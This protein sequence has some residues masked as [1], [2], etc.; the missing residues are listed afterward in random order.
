MTDMHGTH[1][2]NNISER[3]TL[4]PTS[5]QELS[6][7][8]FV[9]EPLDPEVVVKIKIVEE[10]FGSGA[11]QIENMQGQC[12]DKGY[13]EE[14]SLDGVQL[15]Q[16]K[17]EPS[18][19]EDTYYIYHKDLDVHNETVEMDN[20][21]VYE[22]MIASSETIS[23]KI[24]GKVNEQ[25]KVADGDTVTEP[26][27]VD[28]DTVTEPVKVVGGTVNE[29]VKVKKATMAVKYKNLKESLKNNWSFLYNCTLLWSNE[30]CI[31]YAKFYHGEATTIQLSVK[32]RSDFT[33]LIQVHGMN[34]SP[35][36]VFW[37]GLPEKYTTLGDIVKLLTKLHG[38]TVC[39]GN[40]DKEYQSLIK[41]HVESCQ[42]PQAYVEGDFGAVKDGVS[43]T[44]SIR[45]TAC[46]LLTKS[47][48]CRKCFLYRNMLTKAKT[49]EMKDKENT[50]SGE[51]NLEA[52]LMV[53]KGEKPKSKYGKS[54]SFKCEICEKEF[55]Q[56]SYRK[57]HMRIHTGEKPYQCQE[58]GKSFIKKGDLN[59]HMKSHSDE[60][61]FQCYLCEKAFK[62]KAS[63]KQ[64]AVTH[65]GEKPHTCEQC[66]RAFGLKNSLVQHQ[67]THT[68]EKPFQCEQCGKSFAQFA[69]LEAHLMIHKGEKTKIKYG[70]SKSIKCEICEK[71]F[72]HLSRYKRHMRI[73]TGERPYQC[74]V[75]GKSYNIRGSLNV[76]MKNHSDE[77]PFQC[78]ICEKA[79]NHKNS[80]KLH[81]VTHSSEKPHTCEQCG[82][83]FAL[84]SNL[85]RHQRT[86]TGEKPFQ[87][88]QCGKAFI[89]ST[90]LIAHTKTHK[91]RSNNTGRR[92]KV[93]K[94][95]SQDLET[96]SPK[97]ATVEYLGVEIFNGDHNI[98]E[99]QP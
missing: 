51:T 1:E 94:G 62:L 47:K 68:G 36:H 5:Q 33:P 72:A 26:M 11:V 61:P 23:L 45:S 37:S 92:T 49:Q 48:R 58:C 25:V 38:F 87:C 66:G 21:H 4:T 40:P 81:A 70:K 76:H 24:G 57:T 29:Q 55:A 77:K 84:K 93:E 60:R 17:K 73:H 32:I 7:S 71:E 22:C 16:V 69:N 98:L 14:T 97:L 65:S 46:E 8:V 27:K 10:D 99:F 79:F 89:Q 80:L 50:L 75:C 83:A 3:V 18:E 28:G 19:Y 90:H 95:L 74:E 15:R 53:H 9:Q 78:N 64:H 63:L 54:K 44:S 88:E 35:E 12:P 52:H 13:T 39:M 30:N 41:S 42:P 6:H 82:L 2:K 85:V 56:T 20:N 67:R 91:S 59:S 96:G 86:H 34:V 43:Y 31:E